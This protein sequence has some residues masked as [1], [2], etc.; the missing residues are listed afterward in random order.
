MT[1]LVEICLTRNRS[2]GELR[3]RVILLGYGASLF[4]LGIA[5]SY[6]WRGDW[7]ATVLAVVG[8]QDYRWSLPLG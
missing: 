8:A 4:L 3:R 2:S 6:A 5:S 1:S 7:R